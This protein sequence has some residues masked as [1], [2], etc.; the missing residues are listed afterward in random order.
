M[1]AP[2]RIGS[3]MSTLSIGQSCIAS[4]YRS[5]YHASSAESPM[6]IANA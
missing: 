1:T 3:Q 4:C 6:T 2:P 5:T